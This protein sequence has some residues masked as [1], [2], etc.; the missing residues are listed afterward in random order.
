MKSYF[1]SLFLM[2]VLTLSSVLLFSACG[3]SAGNIKL[4][5]ITT[6]KDGFKAVNYKLE[7]TTLGAQVDE[8]L[9]KLTSDV[10]SVSYR[11]LVPSEVEITENKIA[12]DGTVTLNFN[13]AYSQ[14]DT[15]TEVLVRYCLVKSLTQIDGVEAVAIYVRN[16]PLTDSAGN[17][18][19]AMTFDSF[20]EDFSNE[21][22]SMKSVELNLYFASADGIS[23]V[24]ET[25]ELHY[26]SNISLERLIMDR[27]MKGPNLTFLQRAIASD[28]KLISVYTLD[29]VC[30]VNFDST[31]QTTVSGVTGNVTIYSIVNSLTELD[32]IDAVQFMVGGDAASI[33]TSNIN[34]SA[35]VTRN[36]DII[37][38]ISQA[39]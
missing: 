8:V 12:G 13:S 11:K 5:Y 10:N 7:S 31:F 4:Y 38:V 6:D 32:Y 19:G 37:K 27:L 2:L 35:P 14:L 30:Y 29:N 20:I 18:V 26:S 17:V 9:G 34:L 21:N 24:A 1:K 33:P 28:A 22:D 15:Y 39:Q 3:N 23:C 36:E 16:E 25:R